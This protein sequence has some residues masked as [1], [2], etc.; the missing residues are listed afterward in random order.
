MHRCW[1]H[2]TTRWSNWFHLLITLFEKIQQC[3][4]ITA[5][6]TKIFKKTNWSVLVTSGYYIWFSSTNIRNRKSQWGFESKYCLIY[7][8]FCITYLRSWHRGTQ[9]APVY[10]LRLRYAANHEVDLRVSQCRRRRTKPQVT[11]VENLVK[12]SEILV[13]TDTHTDIHIQ[14]RSSRYFAPL[15][16]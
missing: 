14:T 10:P 4:V 11:R 8:V 13:R 12:I 16:E 7:N 5:N 9:P 1:K 15:P 6:N 2:L 3:R